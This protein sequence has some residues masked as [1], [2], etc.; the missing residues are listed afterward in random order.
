VDKPR[1]AG[2]NSEGKIISIYFSLDSRDVCFAAD[3]IKAYP[4]QASELATL[5]LDF[6]PRFTRCV[7]AKRKM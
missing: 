7:F 4:K 5:A 2:C 6:I 1:I 3:K